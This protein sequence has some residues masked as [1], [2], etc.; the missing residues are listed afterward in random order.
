METM[1][2][3]FAKKVSKAER[4]ASLSHYWLQTL[5]SFLKN[6]IHSGV[7]RNCCY[8]GDCSEV[9]RGNHISVLACI[10]EAVYDFA[11]IHNT[12]KLHQTV[13]HQKCSYALRY[14]GPQGTSC[15]FIKV[16]ANL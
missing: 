14:G 16:A 2:I 15:K 7:V 5:P 3:A 9:S 6:E 10:T 13:Q 4:K 8:H 11:H 12:V 1:H